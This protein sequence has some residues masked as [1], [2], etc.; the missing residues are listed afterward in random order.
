[1]ENIKNFHNTDMDKFQYWCDTQGHLLLGYLRQEQ[2]ESAETRGS[3]E[4]LAVFV[5]Q[6][7]SESSRRQKH[8]LLIL[9][10]FME[11]R[12]KLEMKLNIC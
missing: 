12:P 11:S 2:L 10:G 9:W 5:L 3:Y 8:L 7:T 1:M 6:G 4:L